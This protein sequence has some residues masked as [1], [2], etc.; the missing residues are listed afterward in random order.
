MFNFRGGVSP[1]WDALGFFIG[2]LLVPKL[3]AS[4]KENGGFRVWGGGG[5][6]TPSQKRSAGL[7]LKLMIGRQAFPFGSWH[8]FRCS[9]RRVVLTP[10]FFQ[11]E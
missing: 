4:S 6:K 3:I 2:W 1:P 10:K 7:P 8:I 11:F 9:F 5:G